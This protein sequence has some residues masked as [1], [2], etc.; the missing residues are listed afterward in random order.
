MIPK[1]ASMRFLTLACCFP[2]LKHI[3]MEF[4][5]RHVDLLKTGRLSQFSRAWA[6]PVERSDVALRYLNP[7]PDAGQRR[8]VTL[9]WP[10]PPGGLGGIGTGF[11]DHD[12]VQMRSE[13]KS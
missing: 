5:Q 1:Q 11:D 12:H 9:D 13:E 4:R 8:T 3:E 7:N 6:G 2:S 10:L